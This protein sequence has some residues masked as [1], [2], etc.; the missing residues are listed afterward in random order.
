MAVR[1]KRDEVSSLRVKIPPR[2][3]PS[4][5]ACQTAAYVEDQAFLFQTIRADCASVVASVAGIDRF[6]D[7]QALRGS[8]TVAAGCWPSLTRVSYPSVLYV[9]LWRGALVGR[10]T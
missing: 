9:Y 2:L 4:L 10:R 3:K 5:Q 8:A 7:L 1:L 6:S